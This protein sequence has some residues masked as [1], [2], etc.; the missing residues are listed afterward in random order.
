[1]STPW[2][3]AAGVRGLLLV[4]GAPNR[5]GAW[6]RRGLVACRV[7]PLGR[8]TAVV[9]AESSSRARPPYDDAIT[10]LTARRLPARLRPGFALFTSAG[11]AVVSV[12]P[13]GFRASQRWLVWETGGGVVTTTGLRAAHP[14]DLARAAGGGPGLGDVLAEPGGDPDELLR[15]VMGALGLP[16]ADLLGGA[17]RAPGVVVAPSGRTVARFEARVAE[18]ARHRA[19]QEEG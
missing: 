3:P 1:M 16:G 18:E 2:Q 12:Q 19:E 6:V 13:R 7:V 9:P 17:A 4:S 15:R 14:V 11:R 10:V 5:V 8:W